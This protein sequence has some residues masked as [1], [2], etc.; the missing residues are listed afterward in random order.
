MADFLVNT[1]LFSDKRTLPE[2]AAWNA[3]AEEFA[4]GLPKTGP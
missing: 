1:G 3:F 2:Y 4:A